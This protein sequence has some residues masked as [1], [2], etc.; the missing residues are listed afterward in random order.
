MRIKHL[1]VS[2]Q[3]ILPDEL[4]SPFEKLKSRQNK[5]NDNLSWLPA[6][7]MCDWMEERTRSTAPVA[8]VAI[9]GIMKPFK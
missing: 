2:N 9:D 7:K 6:R 8:T 3:N 4:F 5:L 1:E